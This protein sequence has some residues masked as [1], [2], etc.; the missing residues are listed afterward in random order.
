MLPNY[1]LTEVG[2]KAMSILRLAGLL[3]DAFP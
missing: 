3:T 1:D 2:E